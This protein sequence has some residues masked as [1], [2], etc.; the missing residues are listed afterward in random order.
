LD[1]LADDI[2]LAAAL[3]GTDFL[4][5]GDSFYRLGKLGLSREIQNQVGDFSRDSQIIRKTV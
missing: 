1:I 4:A 3:M 5:P 2:F